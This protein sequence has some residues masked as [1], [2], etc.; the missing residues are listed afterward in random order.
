MKRKSKQ[1]NEKNPALKSYK[2]L[3]II[4]REREREKSIYIYIYRDLM[5]RDLRLEVDVVPGRRED[6]FHC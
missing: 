4:K 1:Q 3:E 2:I 5:K 6:A